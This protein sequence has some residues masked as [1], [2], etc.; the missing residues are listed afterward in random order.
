MR[1]LKEFAV[2]RT[3]LI[4]THSMSAS[5][6]SLVDRIVVMEDSHIVGDG[7]HEQLLKECP[8]YNRLYHAPSKQER[9]AA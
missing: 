5:L 7:N 8:L 6:L 4:I 2:G 3:V 9:E 1:T